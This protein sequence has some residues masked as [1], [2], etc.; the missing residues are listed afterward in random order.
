M[1]MYHFITEWFFPVPVE[2]VWEETANIGAYPTWW[3]NLKKAV[4]RGPESRL[5]LGSIV[6]CEVKGS[7]PFSLRFTIEVTTFDPPRL[8]EIKS[9]GDLIG[10]GKWT[11]ESKDNGTQSI[12]HWDVGTTNPVLNIIARIPFV[13]SMLEKNHDDVM[14]KGYEVINARFKNEL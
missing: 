11:L 8:L 9:T 2:R 10:T 6:D 14:A 7:L 4:I 12:F 1:G 3:K 5:Q 13:K